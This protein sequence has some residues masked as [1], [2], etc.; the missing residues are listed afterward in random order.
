MTTDLEEGPDAWQ[1]ACVEPVVVD[2]Q[3]AARGHIQHLQPQPKQQQQQPFSVIIPTQKGLRAA[4]AAVIQ[5]H[6]L[7]S[8][9]LEEQPTRCVMR[10]QRQSLGH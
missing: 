7:R 3:A 8:R 9:G 2:R 10:H 6:D 5:R 4:A 1:A